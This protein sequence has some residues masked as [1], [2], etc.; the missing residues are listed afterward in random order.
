[1]VVSSCE[2]ARGAVVVA[3]SSYEDAPLGH[4]TTKA[5]FPRAAPFSISLHVSRFGVAAHY[6][7]GSCAGPYHSRAAG[8]VVFVVGMEHGRMGG[9]AMRQRRSHLLPQFVLLGFMVF[10]NTCVQVR[11]KRKRG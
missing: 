9:M 6:A 1:M 3:A 11:A 5:S 2:E 10:I 8:G 4:E 7:S